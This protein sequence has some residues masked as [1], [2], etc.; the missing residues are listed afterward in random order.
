MK[1]CKTKFARIALATR[2][3]SGHLDSSEIANIPWL[4][5]TQEWNDAKLCKEFGISEELWNYIDKFSPDYYNDY[6]S[7]FEK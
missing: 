6:E 3:N 2:K 1:Y 5:F 4:D 7:G